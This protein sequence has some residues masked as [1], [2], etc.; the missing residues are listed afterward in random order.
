MAS[1]SGS[2]YYGGIGFFGLFFLVLFVLK[3][4]GKLTWSWWWVTAPVWGPFVLIVGIT[5]LIVAVV[6]LAKGLVRFLERRNKKQ[7]KT[8]PRH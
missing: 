4:L 7:K 8:L 5:M 2:H 3:V 6:L 1:G